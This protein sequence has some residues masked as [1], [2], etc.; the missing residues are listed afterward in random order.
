[1]LMRI[2]HIDAIARQKQRDVLYV[3]FHPRASDMPDEEE[4]LGTDDFDLG[5]TANTPADHRLAGGAGHRLQ[6]LRPFRQR[7]FDDGLPWA[8]LCRCAI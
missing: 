3:A 8:N 1:M 5:E 6:T 2:E 7:V 4:N